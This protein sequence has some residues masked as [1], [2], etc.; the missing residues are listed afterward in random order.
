MLLLLRGFLALAERLKEYM[1]WNPA[2]RR[3]EQISQGCALNGAPSG[4]GENFASPAQSAHLPCY[5]QLFLVAITSCKQ[6]WSRGQRWGAFILPGAGERRALTYCKCVH[7][8]RTRPC[9]GGQTSA[10]GKEGMN[11]AGTERTANPGFEKDREASYPH[12]I[13]SLNRS[14]CFFLWETESSVR[15]L[16]QG[17]WKSSSLL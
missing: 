3:A 6:A 16:E 12:R 13:Q 17:N 7:S 4:G 14:S 9:R 2:P 15:D 1:I 10:L 8:K 11:N 5:L